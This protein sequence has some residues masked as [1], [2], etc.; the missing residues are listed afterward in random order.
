MIELFLFVLM[1]FLL[2][3][4]FWIMESLTA[5][6]WHLIFSCCIC[7]LW[8]L[9]FLNEVSF[10]FYADD[11]QI[12][13]PLK[14]DDRK[15]AL[16]SLSACLSFLN[17]YLFIFLHLTIAKLSLLCLGPQVF[18]VLLMAPRRFGLLCKILCWVLLLI[19]PSNLIN[20]L[21]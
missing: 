2:L 16:S 12:Y 4:L 13:L 15:K 9:F 17:F 19:L 7:F 21:L 14:K 3:F 18:R 11:T 1:G 5:P 8:L 20:K 6:F 10:H